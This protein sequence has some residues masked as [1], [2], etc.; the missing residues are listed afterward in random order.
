M[1]EA[2]IAKILEDARSAVNTALEEGG[3]SAA[4]TIAEA[5]NEA[6]LLLQ[7]SMDE[8]AAL[9]DEIIRRRMTVA[10]LE[11]RKLMLA[12]KKRALD[13]IFKEA[14]EQVLSLK[15]D[16]YLKIISGMLES[17]ED[18]DTVKIAARD[19]GVITETFLKK[20]A[21]SKGINLSLSQEFADIKGGIILCSGNM[22]KNLSLEVELDALR[23]QLEP[24]VA[25]KLF[26]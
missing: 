9:Q 15:K 1:S 12:A 7:K 22:E 13:G 4:A 14:A 21:E 25:S 19:K 23:E 20:Y 18:G 2:I 24:E 6:S 26:G 3:K 10:N 16:R 8:T 11:V 5:R 17:A